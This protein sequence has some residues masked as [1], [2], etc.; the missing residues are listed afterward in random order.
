MSASFERRHDAK[1]IV[2]LS[3]RDGNASPLASH[4]HV[5]EAA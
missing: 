5:T 2:G 4:E 3:L 1:V